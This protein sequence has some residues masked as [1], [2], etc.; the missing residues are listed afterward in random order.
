MVISVLA[1]SNLAYCQVL[2]WAGQFTG[3]FKNEAT[4]GIVMDNDYKLYTAG[5]SLGTVDFDS[6]E[7]VFNLSSDWPNIYFTK[8]DT[9]GTFLWARQILANSELTCTSIELDSSGNIFITGF[10]SGTADFDPSTEDYILIK[11]PNTGTS[12]FIAKYSA[13]GNF[14]WVETLVGFGNVR[15]LD[16]ACDENGELYVTGIFNWQVDFDPSEAV[17]NLNTNGLDGHFFIA[18]YSSV[19]DLVWV[20]QGFSDLVSTGRAVEVDY[21]G[22]IIYAGD[23]R[24]TVDFNFGPES[25]LLGGGNGLN[26]FVSKLDPN[27]NFLWARHYDSSSRIQVNDVAIG[28]NNEVYCT[29]VHASST[30]Y[31]PSG[32]GQPISMG[33]QD[34]I[35][36]TAHYADSSFNW[37]RLYGGLHRDRGEAITVSPYGDIYFTGTMGG[38]ND[39]DNGPM[40]YPMLFAGTEPVPFIARIRPNGTFHWAMSVESTNSSFAF[41]S[42]GTGIVVDDQENVYTAG[43]F[44]GNANFNWYPGAHVLSTPTVQPN[45]FISKYKT[46]ELYTEIAIEACGSYAHSAQGQLYTESGIYYDTLRTVG[47][48]CDSILVFNLTIGNDTIIEE[49]AS[50]CGTFHWSANNLSYSESGTYTESF[51][52]VADCDSVRVLNLTVNAAH[53]YNQFPD[54]CESFESDAGNVYT[55]S[56][57]YVETF[58]TLAGCDSIYTFNVSIN[59]PSDT[60]ISVIACDAF[61]LNDGGPIYDVSGLYTETLT[62]QA[63]C[64]S[65]ISLDLSILPS[66]G[67]TI[68]N[69]TSCTPYI[70]QLTGELYDASG[71]YS[72]YMENQFGCDSVTTLDL[73]IVQ[74]DTT[75]IFEGNMLTSIANADAYQWIRCDQGNAPIAG[76]TSNSYQ[77]TEDGLY[78]LILIDNDCVD[79]TACK[80][81]VVSL[82]TVFS[83]WDGI[84]IYPNPTRDKSIIHLG[85]TFDYLDLS[86]YSM[87]GEETINQHYTNVGTIELE[88][89]GASGTYVIRLGTKEHYKYFKILL[90]D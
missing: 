40:I 51:A 37:V 55:E 34:N 47:N 48:F 5:V 73:E 64:D 89:T 3:P 72:L 74:I 75:I 7:A 41:N 59:T 28:P 16:I 90:L 31:N 14:I 76:A 66:S 39:M 36:V 12:S 61:Q 33:G 20:H 35:F 52:G 23:F 26:G 30:N 17:F 81:V 4:G 19:G 70:W 54:V 85:R 60:L 21:D 84:S 9:S 82:S 63:G 67:E 69:V 68:F 57:V 32:G 43:L 13:E 50:S 45:S 78:A 8:Y 27:G 42:R 1:F 77:V 65:L 22:N 80:L 86:C 25:F 62:N 53:S 46:C 83:M 88:L 24:D 56:G 71:A 29:G 15:I 18:R 2:V 11:P 87:L 79:T 6:G 44:T 38:I 49:N 10:W 58:T